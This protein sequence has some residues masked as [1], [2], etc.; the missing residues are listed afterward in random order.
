[1]SDKAFVQG[2]RCGCVLAPIL[3][4]VL[5]CA[6]VIR[7]CSE[8]MSGGDGPSDHQL[9]VWKSDLKKRARA[10]VND[11]LWQWDAWELSFRSWKNERVDIYDDSATATGDFHLMNKGDCSYIVEFE[12]FDA[13]GDYAP[14]C[15]RTYVIGVP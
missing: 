1:M 12:L 9:S 10:E 2:F 13:N 6:G 15:S 5:I 14:V 8:A 11:Y 7:S 3:L 4:V